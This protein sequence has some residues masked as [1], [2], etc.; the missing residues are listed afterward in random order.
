MQPG[1]R[2]LYVSTVRATTRA[3]YP[4]CRPTRYAKERRC[5][6]IWPAISQARIARRAGSRF[7]LTFRREEVSAPELI[8][9]IAGRYPIRD[10]SLE[11]PDIEGAMRRI[12]ESGL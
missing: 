4:V 12:Y 9:A 5:A 2:R 8:A 1:S 11:E 6:S 3:A 10:L 7:W